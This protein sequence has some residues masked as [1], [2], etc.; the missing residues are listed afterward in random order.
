M[1][2][3]R[4]WSHATYRATWPLRLVLALAGTMGFQG[5]IKWWS[6]RHRLHHRYTDTDNDPYNAKYGFWF[7]HIGWI[8]KKP[9]YPRM[10][11]VDVS[12]LTSDPSKFWSIIFDGEYFP[13]I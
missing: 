2:Y 4:L 1:G 5:S 7:S 13:I 12:D 3:H 9:Y 11:L 8:F 10:S 6:Q